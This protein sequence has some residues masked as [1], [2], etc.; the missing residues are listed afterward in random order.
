MERVVIAVGS[1]QNREQHITAA[2]DALAI[3][4][5]ELQ[6]S[7]VYQSSAKQSTM[8]EEQPFYYNLVVAVE[9]ELSIDD[10]KQRLLEIE[11]QCGRRYDDD[12]LVSLDLD[13]LLYGDYVGA[14]NGN[15]L[16]HDDIL[17]CAYVLR[18]L[19]DLLPTQLHPRL[20]KNYRD[21]WHELPKTTVLLA[22]DFVWHERV[23]STA[24]CLPL[25]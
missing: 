19:A 9:T 22:V 14:V 21:L 16:P 18:P 20:K 13:L 15:R 7:P 24:A 1:N 2:L 12:C 3:H 25:V 23:V 6:L 17:D 4:F 10:V 11:H 5:G 8:N